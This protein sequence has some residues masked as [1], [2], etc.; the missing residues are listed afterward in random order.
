MSLTLYYHPLSSY[1]HKAL[2]GL[3]ELGT[4]FEPRL[5]DLSQPDDRDALAAVWP[6]VKFP[7]LHDAATTSSCTSAPSTTGPSRLAKMAPVDDVR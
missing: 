1:C 2:E 6:L 5:I 7:V 4:P 3:Y